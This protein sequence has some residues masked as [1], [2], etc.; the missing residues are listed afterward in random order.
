MTF[1][2]ISMHKLIR[3]TNDKVHLAVV[4]GNDTLTFSY[5]YN[6]KKKIIKNKLEKIIKLC[7]SNK[8][9]NEF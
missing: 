1:V 8:L 4:Q 5:N 2:I 9:I 7:L 3:L 6:E